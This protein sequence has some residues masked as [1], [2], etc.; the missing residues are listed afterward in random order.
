MVVDDAPF[1]NELIKTVMKSLGHLCVGEAI[2]ATEAMDL[3]AKTLPDLIFVDLVMPK[4]NGVTLVRELREIWPN[5]IY[6][7]CTT[8]SPSELP[9]PKD[10]E[11]FDAWLTKPF[12]R[13]QVERIT[14]A[15]E[16]RTAR[17]G[18]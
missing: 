11:L 10:A 18:S 5:G 2:D 13:E 7:A 16:G 17:V 15:L 4:K 9:H 14:R 6:V 1:I 3:L 8:L 12:K